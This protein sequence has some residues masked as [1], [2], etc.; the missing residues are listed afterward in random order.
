MRIGTA[1]TKGANTGPGKGLFCPDGQRGF[2]DRGGNSLELLT[3]ERV[4]L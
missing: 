4:Y 1:I 3:N 2:I